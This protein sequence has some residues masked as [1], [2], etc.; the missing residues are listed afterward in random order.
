MVSF[1][2]PGLDLDLINGKIY[3][4][5]TFVNTKV[6][7]TDLNGNG[8]EVLATGTGCQQNGFKVNAAADRMYFACVTFQKI[9]RSDLNFN[10]LVDF[11]QTPGEF[12]STIDLDLGSGKIYWVNGFGSRSR[13]S[14]DGNDIQ[15]PY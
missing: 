13:A 15:N 4:V 8:I 5:G 7:R 3:G 6:Y 11:I 9:Q 1:S 12:P 10:G 2:G 14:L